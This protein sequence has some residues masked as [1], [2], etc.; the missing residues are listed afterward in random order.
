MLDIIGKNTPVVES[1]NVTETFETSNSTTVNE[2]IQ[3][4]PGP[5][6]NKKW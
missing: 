5:I 4:N 6:I 3:R 1:L 2:E